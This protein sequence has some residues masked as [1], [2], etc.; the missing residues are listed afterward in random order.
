[1]HFVSAKVQ[2]V[3]PD[4]RCQTRIKLGIDCDSRAS[5]NRRS[6]RRARHYATGRRTADYRRCR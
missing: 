4:F 6:L 3:K 2:S 5:H 1:M